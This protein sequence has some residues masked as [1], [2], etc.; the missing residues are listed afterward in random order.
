MGHYDIAA[1]L[2]RRLGLGSKPIVRR[3]FYER[4]EGLVDAEPTEQRRER[5]YQIIAS[6]AADSDGKSDPGR[7]FCFTVNQRLR[8]ARMISTPS[9]ED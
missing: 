8:E 6:A 7:Y 9:L 2:Q 3:A 5:I 1:K 4:L